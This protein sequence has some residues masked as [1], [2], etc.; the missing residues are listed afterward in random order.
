MDVI[1][2][3]ATLHRA[4]TEATDEPRPVAYTCGGLCL[5]PTADGYWMLYGEDGRLIELLYHPD[6]LLD[7][8]PRICNIQPPPWPEQT[9]EHR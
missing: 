5:V 2:A 8:P 9:A 6:G 1:E 3:L 4:A 7:P